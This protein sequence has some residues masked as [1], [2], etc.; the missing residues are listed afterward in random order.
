MPDVAAPVPF[1]AYVGPNPYVFVSYAHSD[2]SFVFE[3]LTWLRDAGFRIWFDEGIDPGNEWPEEVALALE[4]ASAFLVYVS[5]RSIE[6]RNVR[7]EINYALNRGLPF[8]AVHIE[9]TVL[10]PG[11]ALRMGDIQALLRWRMSAENYR[12]KILKV[13]PAQARVLANSDKDAPLNDLRCFWLQDLLN[14]ENPHPRP[15]HII[16]GEHEEENPA[17]NDSV[18]FD[19]FCGETMEAWYFHSDI[20]GKTGSLA[21][22]R[23]EGYTLCRKCGWL[24]DQWRREGRTFPKPE[25]GLP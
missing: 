6:S 13:L 14:L 9:E 4:R 11:L 20:P 2:G 19:A 7:N 18:V 3:D 17:G 1:S 15:V 23:R 10:P 16:E 21:E 5:S 8:I 12:G 22:A 24:Y 25:R